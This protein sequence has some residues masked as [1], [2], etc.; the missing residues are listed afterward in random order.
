VKVLTNSLASNDVKAAHSGYMKYREDL[1]RM[2]VRIYEMKP[3]SE[4]ALTGHRRERKLGSSSQGALH[5]KTFVSDRK[6]VFIG[7]FN[8]DPRSALLDTQDGMLVQGPEMADHVARIFEEGASPDAAYEVTLE[9][10]SPKTE[11]N[12]PSEGR[13][14]WITRENGEEVR[15]YHEPMTS[16]WQRIK[17]RVFSWFVPEEML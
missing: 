11:G 8:Y 15:Y 4:E 3:T 1:L 6:R 13:L 16:L 14:T 7:S 10:D 12:A 9:S 17:A 2:G 5:A